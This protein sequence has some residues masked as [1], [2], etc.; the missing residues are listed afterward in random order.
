[1]NS[2]CLFGTM[3]P[4]DKLSGRAAA[5]VGLKDLVRIVQIG[6]DQIEFRKVV[7]HV[8]RQGTI[9]REESRQPPRLNRP[10]LVDQSAQARQLN[11]MGI[12]QH[13]QVRLRKMLPQRRQRRQR[14]DEIP[15][16]PAA[17]YQNLALKWVHAARGAQNLVSPNTRTN[18]P[19]ASRTPQLSLTRFSLAVSHSNRSRKRHGE[20]VNQI[21]AITST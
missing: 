3:R 15:N 1:M 5:D 12:P 11:N 6:K 13:L 16:R 20:T 17:N 7:G 4:L 21:P 19:K 9:A 18:N 2:R 10:R 14:Q 8:F